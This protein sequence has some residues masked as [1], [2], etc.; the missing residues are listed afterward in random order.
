MFGIPTYILQ[1][2]MGI[3]EGAA[4]AQTA[5]EYGDRI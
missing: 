2:C 1:R 3:L 4:I 5:E